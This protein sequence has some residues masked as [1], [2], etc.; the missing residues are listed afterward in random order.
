MQ[1]FEILG[2]NG[3]EDEIGVESARGRLEDANEVLIPYK[4]VR[5]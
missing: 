3:L 4:Q 2:S 1:D 5:E